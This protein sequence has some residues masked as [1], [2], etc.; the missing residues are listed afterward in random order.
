MFYTMCPT[1]V[2][3][4]TVRKQ[5]QKTVLKVIKVLHQAVLN[6]NMLQSLTQAFFLF[7]KSRHNPL[8]YQPKPLKVVKPAHTASTSTVTKHLLDDI[9]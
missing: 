9:P 1:S 6:N 5:A 3:L 7:L 8:Q 4:T 2:L